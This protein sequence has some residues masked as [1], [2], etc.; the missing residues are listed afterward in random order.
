MEQTIHFIAPEVTDLPDL[1]KLCWAIIDLDLPGFLPAGQARAVSNLG[2]TSAIRSKTF[3]QCFLM[4]LLQALE[5][6][7]NYS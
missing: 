2:F 3:G 5:F 6:L 7:G 1:G 4:P